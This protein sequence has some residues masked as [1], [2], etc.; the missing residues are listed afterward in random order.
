MVLAALLGF[1]LGFVASIPIAGP[2]SALVLRR[3]LEGR[4][5][6]AGWLAFGGGLAEAGWAF[7]AFFGFA[8]LFVD[9]PLILPISRAGGAIVLTALGVSF[10]RKSTGEP[11]VEDVPQDSAWSSFAV[12]ASL[13]ALNPTLLATWTAAVTTIYATKAL[14]FRGALALPFAVGV[15][16]GI[17]GWFLVLI[18]IIRRYRERFSYAALARTVRFIGGGL[19]VLAA[20]FVVQLVQGLLA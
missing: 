13:G 15:C 19:L 5:R 17:T 2:I 7:L 20:W 10:L 12:G 4:F 8:A 3:G 6:A 16:S 18:V 14:D 1:V 9:Y 11:Q